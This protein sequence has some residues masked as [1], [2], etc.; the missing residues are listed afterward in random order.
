MIARS[1][2]NS[3]TSTSSSIGG[4]WSKHIDSASGKVYYF[5]AKK[6][7][8]QWDAPAGFEVCQPLPAVVAVESSPHSLEESHGTLVVEQKDT[9]PQTS[10]STVD[11]MQGW[12]QLTDE[13]S[14]KLY[15]YNA[16]TGESQWEKPLQLE[17]PQNDMHYNDVEASEQSNTA[18]YQYSVEVS[19][20]ECSPAALEVVSSPQIVP[21]EES[22]GTLV[23]RIDSLPQTN[24]VSVDEMQGWQQLTDE[25]SGKLYYYNA[26]T[27]ESQWEK[28]LQLESPQNDMHYND[29]PTTTVEA[30]EQSNTAELLPT[31]MEVECSPQ[32]IPSEESYRTFVEQNNDSLPQTSSDTVDEVQGWQQ[33]TDETSGKL[34]YY[35][36]ATGESQWEKPLQLEKLENEQQDANEPTSDFLDQPAAAVKATERSETP[37][38][39]YDAPNDFNLTPEDA[40]PK[41]MTVIMPLQDGPIATDTNETTDDLA[42]GWRTITDPVAGTYFLNEVTGETSWEFPSAMERPRAEKVTETPT[43]PILP[44]SWTQIVDPASGSCYFYNEETGETSWDFPAPGIRSGVTLSEKVSVEN[45][46]PHVE[47]EG[48]VNNLLSGSE[49]LHIR[50][51]DGLILEKKD[52]T[53]EVLPAGWVKV[54][55]EATLETY[56]FNEITGETA[57]TL[58]S[59]IV[60]VDERQ[61]AVDTDTNENIDEAS[62]PLPDGWSKKIDISSRQVYYFNQNTGD[63]SWNAP[64]VATMTLEVETCTMD[65]DEAEPSTDGLTVTNAQDYNPSLERQNTQ[66]TSDSINNQVA[67]IEKDTTGN[68][69]SLIEDHAAVNA[70]LATEH[71]ADDSHDPSSDFDCWETLRDESTGMYYYLNTTTGEATW[72]SPERMNKNMSD[73][74]NDGDPEK[75]KVESST[76]KPGSDNIPYLLE[77]VNTPVEPSPQ[78]QSSEITTCA[79]PLPAGWEM[80]IDPGSGDVY[81]YNEEQ[82]ETSWELPIATREEVN[83]PAQEPMLVSGGF[84]EPDSTEPKSSASLGAAWVSVEDPSSG[85]VY[86]YNQQSGE[87]S[88]DPPSRT[89]PDS[90]GE[91]SVATATGGDTFQTSHNKNETSHAHGSSGELRLNEETK[92]SLDGRFVSE[93]SDD[94][95]PNAS[96]IG[97][98]IQEDDG[99]GGHSI[100]SASLTK[101]ETSPSHHIDSRRT[102]SISSDEQKEK[103]K[104]NLK[105]ALPE[106]GPEH[107]KNGEKFSTRNESIDGIAV[108]DRNLPVVSNNFT[109]SELEVELNESSQVQA[110]SSPVHG[111]EQ[112][113]DESS[114][115]VCYFNKQTGETSWE[116][117]VL[118]ASSNGSVQPSCDLRNPS[119]SDDTLPPGWE[120][121]LDTTS[122]RHYYFNRVQNTTSWDP[123]SDSSEDWIKVAHPSAQPAPFESS[124]GSLKTRKESHVMGRRGSFASFGF[125]GRVCVSNG[126]PGTIVIHRVSSLLAS[127]VIVAAERAKRGAGFSGPL[128]AAENQNVLAYLEGKAQKQSDLIWSLCLIASHSRGCL[129]SD[130]R[131][132]DSNRPEPAIVD[133]LLS[134]TNE[135]EASEAELIEGKKMSANHCG[136]GEVQFLLLQGKREEAVECALVKEQFALA[137]LVASMCSRETY[138]KAAKSYTESVLRKGSPLHTA[139]ELFCSELQTP[140]MRLGVNPMIWSDSN[141]NLKHTWKKHLA[142][143][144]S[145]R[146]AGWDDLAVALGDRLKELGEVV[147]AHVC[148]MVCGCSLSSPVRKNAKIT[149]LGCD[150]G[151]AEL[152]FLTNDSVESF[153]RAE[154]Y[155][156]AKRR[157]NKNA[158]IQSIQGFKLQYALL[159]GDLGLV[160]EAKMYIVSIKECLDFNEDIDL[161]RE[162][163]HPR[164]VSILTADRLGILHQVLEL[165][166]RYA[167]TSVHKKSKDGRYRDNLP[168]THDA[169]TGSSTADPIVYGSDKHMHGETKR[170]GPSSAMLTKNVHE[171]AT[172]GSLDKVSKSKEALFKI[173]APLPPITSAITKKTT[174]KSAI[175]TS[176]DTLIHGKPSAITTPLRTTIDDKSHAP[177]HP[178]MNKKKNPKPE[179]APRS[180]PPNLQSPSFGKQLSVKTL[181]P[182]V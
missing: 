114:G 121:L 69:I 172:D 45:D 173:Q 42:K 32:M 9:V 120:K 115:D 153:C 80:L 63:I 161:A 17:S 86:F 53:Y 22:H 48:T 126:P 79:H 181:P 156:W 105:K 104:S 178:D 74:D 138:H 21:S 89:V 119:M 58:P 107:K 155:E 50:G 137:F 93:W 15:Y 150:V 91:L 176:K 30:S 166:S 108:N 29:Q 162:T 81:Y 62:G 18:E 71:E 117:P 67:S 106:E 14:G 52:E 169:S 4:G 13:A 123:P 127:H 139:A 170:H 87:T 82:G 159:L 143:I 49:N 41:A 76:R 116:P 3:I 99:A 19:P 24:S 10:S 46:L 131:V 1:R 12:Q 11:E 23:E 59:E 75:V 133:L 130:D 111:W 109:S 165:D 118:L 51:N 174:G 103:N 148:Y 102:R 149:L 85:D 164:F 56:F 112:V 163:L 16:A 37:E 135:N 70:V 145:N 92:E 125:G 36:T 25:T 154:A 147:P 44:E 5:H 33:L 96:E 61:V 20:V 134:N 84:S 171:E 26:A 72:D 38:D 182:C 177:V 31:A 77:D 43:D 39:Q 129:R 140:E 2:S 8:T 66:E 95:V 122:G 101:K 94:Q 34:Y 167:G 68:A 157:G 136:L 27:G 7:I 55:D 6:G 158:A 141:I 57:W 54:E 40:H 152:L 179:Q 60:P 88:W 168:A 151:F 124:A 128:I 132:N 90:A 28:P 47:N 144:I 175:V 78:L 100:F 98:D 180:A 142:A 110:I 64:T 113:V 83:P 73:C 97:N 146:T 160:E 65:N 35:N